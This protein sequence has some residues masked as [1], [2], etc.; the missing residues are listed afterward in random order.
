MAQAGPDRRARLE[1]FVETYRR[2]AA[3]A[4]HLYRLM[5]DR[6][7]PRDRLPDGVEAA[8]MA[9]YV[10]TI[11]DIDLARTGWAWAHGLV[12]LELAGRFPDDADLD[13]GWAIL[14]DTLDTR[15]A[16]PER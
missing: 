14:V 9:D 1:A 7:L 12:S 6:P 2:T 3:A 13:A 4:P 8:A 16:A 10:A 15:A 11:G 5:N